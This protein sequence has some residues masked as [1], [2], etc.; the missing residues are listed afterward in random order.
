[1]SKQFLRF[2]SASGYGLFE[3][4]VILPI[5]LA[6]ILGAVDLIT[7]VKAKALLAESARLVAHEMATIEGQGLILENTQADGP[8][9]QWFEYRLNTANPGSP[10]YQKVSIGG[11]TSAVPSGCGGGGLN[12]CFWRYESGAAEARSHRTPSVDRAISEAGM[13]EIKALMRDTRFDCPID[14]NGMPTESY[15][16]SFQTERGVFGGMEQVQVRAFYKLP[17]IFLGQ[18]T[19]LLRGFAAEVLE[20]EQIDQEVV[21]TSAD[22]P[23]G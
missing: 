10:S 4:A 8:N 2:R 16:V 6:I 17:L 1:M 23:N 20:Q 9:L 3:F 5:M 19:I 18:D 11:S 13:K 22:N 7:M 15:C 14:N 21:H 12:A